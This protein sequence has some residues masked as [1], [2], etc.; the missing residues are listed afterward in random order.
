MNDIDRF[1]IS[2]LVQEI[3]TFKESQQQKQQL[4]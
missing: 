1:P 3:S 4:Q 2:Y